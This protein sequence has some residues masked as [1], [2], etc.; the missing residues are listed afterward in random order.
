MRMILYPFLVLINIAINIVCLFLNPIVVL[1][2]DD[3]GNLPSWLKWFQTFDDDLDAGFRNG[4]TNYKSRYMNRLAWL[5][6][7]SAYG[8][9]YYLLGVPFD[10]YQWEVKKYV[11][12]PELTYFYAAGPNGAFNMYYHGKLGMYKFGWK[13]WNKFDSIS[14]GWRTDSWGPEPRVPLVF[15]PNPFKR[16]IPG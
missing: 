7:N 15:S 16:K 2:A 3:A 6:R 11:N 9:D 1:F 5:F 13:A 12:N 14:F 4:N 8:F 10:G